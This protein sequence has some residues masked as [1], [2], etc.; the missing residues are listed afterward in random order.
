MPSGPGAAY[1]GAARRDTPGKEHTP[2]HDMQQQAQGTGEVSQGREFPGHGP[3]SRGY[4]IHEHDLPQ[5]AEQA[6]EH[7]LDHSVSLH[8][9]HLPCAPCAFPAT[10]PPQTSTTISVPTTSPVRAWRFREPAGG[11]LR[12][13]ALPAVTICRHLSPH[14]VTVCRGGPWSR[15][16]HNP[17]PA[18]PGVMSHLRAGGYR[19]RSSVGMENAL[20]RSSISAPQEAHA[21]RPAERAA[22]P[23]RTHRWV[24]PRR[25]GGK[26]W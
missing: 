12:P 16:P 23:W 4:P 17:S 19:A 25:T 20:C 2:T 11:V 13:L 1:R 5:C 22:S 9:F 15:S 18:A 6:A 24:L 3:P 8:I 7:R 26:T 14:V 21:C 10:F